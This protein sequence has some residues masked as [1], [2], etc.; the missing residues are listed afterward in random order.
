MKRLIIMFVLLILL[1]PTLFGQV[2]AVVRQVSG[3]V[4]LKAP[5]AGW[6]PARTGMNVAKGAFISTGFN[7]SA[8][9]EMGPS[10]VNVKQLTRM[11]LEELIQKEGTVSTGLYLNVG[12]V[13][14]KVK[15]TKGLSNDFKLRTPI[16]TAAV[17]GTEWDTDGFLWE[18]R[19][20]IIALY[21]RLG[22][23]Y[24]VLA[25]QKSKVTAKG[26]L[27]SPFDLAEE[28]TEV[29]TDAGDTGGTG[30]QGA[31]TARGSIKITW[32]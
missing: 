27:Q 13:N 20:G 26:Y 23:V 15:T 18:V 1:V 4:E 7:S 10:V 24:T 17:R 9:L 16:S 6:V 21:G 30:V 32:Q 29:S 22:E 25:K 3:K 2:S 31:Y 28:D 11:Q 8:V 19:E 5:G 14:V 12:K